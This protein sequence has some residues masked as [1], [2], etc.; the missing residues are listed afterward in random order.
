[1]A[2]TWKVTG[3]RQTTSLSSGGTFATVMEV[4]FTTTS[5]V[6]GNITV[7]LSQYNPE[8]VATLINARVAQIDA[9][10]AL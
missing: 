5:G 4:T 9:V 1:M 3:Q 10:H 6:T 8:N 7:P 2:D